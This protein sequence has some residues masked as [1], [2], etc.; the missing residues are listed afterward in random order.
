MAQYKQWEKEYQNP[1]FITGHSE[2]QKFIF[3]FLKYL[4][5]EVGIEIS[6]WKVLD[7]GCGSGRNANYLASQGAE[8]TGIEISDTALKL[9]RAKAKEKNLKI[10]YRIG[11]IGSRFNFPDNYFDLVLDVTSS[12]ALNE[13]EREMYL[14]EVERVLQPKGYFFVRALCKDGDNNAKKMLKLFP[15]KECDTY[16]M[17]E[18]GLVERVFSQADFRDLYSRKFRIIKLIKES[19]YSI[20]GKQKYKRN[21][22]IAY[23]QKK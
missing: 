2:P 18:I 3:R 12:N 20:F 5:R 4:R 19:S 17:P 8:V 10:D 7:L 9:A 16:V 15:G 14:S 11:D 23:L 22:W 13:S 21:F 1:R 6:D